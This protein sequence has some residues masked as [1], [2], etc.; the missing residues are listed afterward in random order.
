MVKPWR[1]AGG[2]W[3][4]LLQPHARPAA[5]GGDEFDAGLFEGSRNRSQ[6]RIYRGAGAAFEVGNR[7]FRDFRGLGE[8][9]A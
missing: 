5:I 1:I 4:V 6:A 3:G 7:P 9:G 8:I 2:E